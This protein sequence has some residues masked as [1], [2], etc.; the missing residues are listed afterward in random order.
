VAPLHEDAI[1]LFLLSDVIELG[2][3]AVGTAATATTNE[4]RERVSLWSGRLRH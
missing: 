3:L 1:E 4:N 2:M